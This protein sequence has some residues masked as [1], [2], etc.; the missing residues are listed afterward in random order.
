MKFTHSL[1]F[2]SVPEW[3]SNYINYHG[4]KKSLYKMTGEIAEPHAEGETVLD[5]EQVCPHASAE[6]I[7]MTTPQP[8]ITSHPQRMHYTTMHAHTSRCRCA[9]H[10]GRR[11]TVP[12][13]RSPATNV[14]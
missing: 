13:L 14:P 3:R 12:R 9:Q 2:N 11:G 5:E 4:L 8:H 6:H 1:K 7:H 10:L